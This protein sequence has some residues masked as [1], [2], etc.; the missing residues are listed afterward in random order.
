MG[1]SCRLLL[2]LLLIPFPAFSGQSTAP[3]QLRPRPPA[4]L[5]EPPGGTGHRITLDVQVA[6]RSHEAVHGLQQQDF[7]VLDDGKPQDILS[8]IAVNG[9]MPSTTALP[10]ELVLV[11]DAV[12][13]PF[14][15]LT[16]ERGE[17]KKFL[18]Q[19]GGQ[20]PLPVSLII[21]SDAG[22]KVQNAA[23]R[24][25]KVLA[26]LYEQYEFRLRDITR[27][28]GFHGATERFDTSLKT[29]NSLA[30]YEKSRPGRKLMI[31]FSPGWPMLSGS[32]VQLSHH[33]QRYLFNSI[34][35]LSS[36]LRQARITLYSI[37]PLGLADA[38]GIRMEYYKEFLDGITS[39]SQ[40]VAGDLGL[41]VLAIQSGGRVFNGGI[42]LPT[43]I[44]SC[45]ADADAFYALSFDAR[46]ANEA[47]QYHS[48]TVVVNKPGITVRTRTGY[49]AQP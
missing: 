14:D 30:E 3:P 45:A 48:L 31:W 32:G 47:D 10:I 19:N 27:S 8:F 41:Q 12:N 43:A 29:L 4:A 38:G 42:D 22:T 34:V 20:L 5:K 40:A 28:Q 39:P 15:S 6:D 24:D 49:Y 18:L 46:P 26:A 2:V 9:G 16:Y 7:T 35:V 17:V 13:T 36:A 1:H 44:R 21:F 37:D 25:G 11:I 23:S 33:D